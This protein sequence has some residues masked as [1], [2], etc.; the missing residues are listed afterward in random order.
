MPS[1]TTDFTFIF[2][3]FFVVGSFGMLM[4]ILGGGGSFHGFKLV[5]DTDSKPAVVPLLM[6][7]FCNETFPHFGQK[8][9]LEGTAVLHRELVHITSPPTNNE[10]TEE[11]DK[12]RLD[13]LIRFTSTHKWVNLY[14]DKAL[15][16]RS[17]SL[18]TLRE[19]KLIDERKCSRE[20]NIQEIN[21]KHENNTTRDRETDDSDDAGC[22]HREQQRGG[23]GVAHKKQATTVR[24]TTTTTSYCTSIVVD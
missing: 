24:S 2:V 1:S 9:A 23:A 6:F 8:K 11:L 3:F 21:A 18:P 17:E 5:L 4:L 22:C 7:I 13:I 19:W 15:S 16:F 14:F 20:R 10:G 12:D